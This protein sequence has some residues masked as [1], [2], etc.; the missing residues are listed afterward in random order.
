MSG[1]EVKNGDIVWAYY[2]EQNVK[3]AKRSILPQIGMIKGNDFVPYAKNGIDLAWSRRVN[4]Y[5]RYYGKTYDEALAG[6]IQDI[7]NA[8]LHIKK[9]IKSL[10]TEL[11][12]IESEKAAARKGKGDSK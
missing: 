10:E 9:M 1:G 8:E 11:S 6:Y 5:S 3:Y 7:D 2:Y 12:R 4:K